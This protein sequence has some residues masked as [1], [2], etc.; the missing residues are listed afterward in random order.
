MKRRRFLLGTAGVVGGG[1]AVGFLWAANKLSRDQQFKL[2]AAQNAASFN[3]WIT[4]ATDGI[5]SVAIPRQEMGQGINT[6][7][8]MYVAEELEVPLS[9]IRIMEAPIAP[10]YANITAFQDG[11]RK[12][13][14]PVLWAVT[15]VAG[16]AGMQVTGGSTSTRDGYVAMRTAAASARELLIAEAAARWNV[17]P[18]TCGA[19]SG[20]V[21]HIP[22]QKSL[23]YGE[24]AAAASA[25]AVPTAVALKTPAQW[26]VLGTSPPRLD[27]P[28]KVDG[29][30]QFGIDITLPN[31]L[32]A[33][34]KHI[35]MVRGA[36]HSVKWKN[37][38][39][40][41]SVVALAQGHDWIAAIATNTW[42]AQKAVSE[43]TL[44]GGGAGGCTVSSDALYK[45][46]DAML[47]AGGGREYERRGT[48]PSEWDAAL[49]A[50]S[51]SP[52]PSPPGGGSIVDVRYR[53]P[54]QAHATMEPLNCTVHWRE[55]KMDIWLGNQSPTMVRW[56][57]ADASGLAGDAI[58]VHTPYLGGGFGRRSDIE[59]LRQAIA[60]AKL[61]NGKPVKLTW[62]REE[63]T[64][65]DAYRPAV[66]SWMRAAFDSKGDI[67]AWDH[68]IAGMS[69]MFDFVRRAAK[70]LAS[71]AA[72]DPT[73]CEGATHL[74]YALPN[75][76]V[77]HAQI[78]EGVPL[79]FWRSV[80]NSY[81]AFFVETFVDELA[82][83]K[84][85]DPYLF[86]KALLKN[87]PRFEK[88][89]DEAAGKAGWA[90][91]LPRGSGRGIAI[92][93]S[94][95]SIVAMVVDVRIEGKAIKVERVVAVIDCG[96]ALHPNNAAAQ[97]EGAIGFALS[98]CVNG[99]ITLKDGVV[100]QSNFNDFQIARLVDMPRV[101][102][103]F[104][105]SEAA[106]GGIGEVGVPPFAPALGNAIFAA[107]GERL[108]E[109]PFSL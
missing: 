27:V 86:R 88:V 75:F 1:L 21:I 81:N 26:K 102:V 2:P 70:P 8:A 73:N 89:L 68:T 6:M 83:K 99:Q 22:T 57:A 13:G 12:Q 23:G 32:Y 40:P 3:A 28:A 17:E 43:A 31:M 66:A 60:C 105:T 50:Q 82:A 63:D 109:L 39:P 61:T 55:G 94:F 98:A 52:Q 30:A 62:S 78:D 93:E 14:A 25:R 20:K 46:Y 76:R 90:T 84:Q 74:P 101:E 71:D 33:A 45:K 34:V 97:I 24:L 107:T 36:L 106:L 42:T 53:V 95:Q 80:G 67:A 35:P 15:K 7:L 69:V 87:A 54:F 41:K 48:I 56:V 65:H 51:P 96:R 79:G 47:D 9:Q 64:R 29:S 10:I 19:V 18:H 92:A 72:P 100:Q 108:R 16:L 11:Y 49:Q 103:H 5:V 44:T 59:V 4:I 91:A 37:G 58:T 104:V 85:D 38:A 77:R